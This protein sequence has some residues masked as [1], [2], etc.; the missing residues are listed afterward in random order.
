MKTKSTISYSWTNT[1]GNTNLETNTWYHLAMTYDGEYVRVFVNGIEDGST[2]KNGLMPI[3]S[4]DV[5]IGAD[6][7]P[8]LHWYFDGIID[9]VRISD[10]ARTEFDIPETEEYYIN[11][12]PTESSI[13]EGYEMDNGSVYNSERGYGW[14]IDLTTETRERNMHS[15]QRLDTLIHSGEEPH[16]F[17]NLDL[18][19]GVYEVTLSSGDPMF[20]HPLQNIIVEGTT[21]LENESTEANEFITRTENLIVSDDQLTLE[22]WGYYIDQLHA[23]VTLNYINIV[24][25]G[26]IEIDTDGDGII[27]SQDNCISTYNPSQTDFDRDRVGDWCDN[28]IMTRNPNQ[29]DSNG[30]Y[31]GNACETPINT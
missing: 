7:T 1:I 9:E 11:F 26:Y 8:P 2:P 20:A 3:V 22:M 21:F 18:P 28:C 19:N 29:E 23:G 30:N 27:D 15:D 6:S 5:H 14:D 24:Y 4:Q 31:I 16:V 13:P 25:I 12:Q 10:I 17:W